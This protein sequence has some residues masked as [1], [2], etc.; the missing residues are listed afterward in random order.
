M[1]HLLANV[2]TCSPFASFK[3]SNNLWWEY[4]SIDFS[5]GVF[6]LNMRKATSSKTKL[7]K[8]DVFMEL[9]LE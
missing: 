7:R 9:L 4:E 8:L 3:V 2:M 1:K 6:K 5:E